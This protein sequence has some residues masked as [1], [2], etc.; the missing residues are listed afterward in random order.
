MLQSK[1]C[2]IDW[3]AICILEPNPQKYRLKI[4][5]KIFDIVKQALQTELFLRNLEA[6]ILK[7]TLSIMS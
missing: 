7:N 6:T 1:N 3:H 4:Y 2:R 5:L